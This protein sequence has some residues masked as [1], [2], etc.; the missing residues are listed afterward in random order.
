MLFSIANASAPGVEETAAF[1]TR[2]NEVILF[3]VITLLTGVALLVFLYGC[4]I[5][6]INS[7]NPSARE[8]GRKHIMYGIIGLLVMLIAYSILSIAANTFG[9]GETLDCSDD[10]SGVG[11]DFIFLPDAG[12]GGGTPGGVGGGNQGGVGGGNQQ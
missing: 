4:A 12:I 9:L 6:I 1:V 11:C 8:D 10:P 2:F 3:P 7:N 5:Y